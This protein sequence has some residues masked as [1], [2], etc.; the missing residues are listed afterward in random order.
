VEAWLRARVL[1][2]RESTPCR[3]FPGRIEVVAAGATATD[4]ALAGWTYGGADALDHA[5]RVDVLVRLLTD[6]GCRGAGTVNLVHVRPG[7]HETGDHDL[8]WAAASR[9]ATGIS[10]VEVERVVA[11]SRW[12]WRDVATGAERSWV[13]LRRR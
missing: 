13:R 1:A 10:G 4:R 3:V 11:V 6:C 12:G 8:A 2:L 5:L 9:I 7:P